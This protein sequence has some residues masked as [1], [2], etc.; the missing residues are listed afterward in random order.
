MALVEWI[1]ELQQAY[2]DAGLADLTADLLPPV[3]EA[4]LR[5]FAQ[6][7]GV[8]LPAEFLALYRLHDGQPPAGVGVPGL[9][10]TYRFI[11]LAQSA[12][13]HQ[14]YGETC[15]IDRATFPPA[16]HEWVSWQPELLPFA[17][18]N[19]CDWCI[20]AQAGTVWAFRPGGGLLRSRPSIAAL[21][22]E[23]SAAVQAGLPAEIS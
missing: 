9:F 23:L 13:Q 5:A 18:C 10:G 8:P 17:T 6:A 15:L 14:L 7:V 2:A 21:V 1:A 3:S 22:R 20:H 12:E 16:P 4:A 11:P 19:D